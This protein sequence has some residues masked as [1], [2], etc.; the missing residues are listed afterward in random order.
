MEDL[1][2]DGGKKYGKAILLG[3]DKSGRSAAVVIWGSTNCLNFLIKADGAH[4][5]RDKWV[6][7]TTA[8]PV[9][10]LR[11]EERP[12]IWRVAANILNKQ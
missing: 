3:I 4:S 11:M 7:V 2:A 1:S 12:P 5:F 6:P 8:W 10:R 9:L